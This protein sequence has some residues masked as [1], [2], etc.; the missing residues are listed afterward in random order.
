MPVLGVQVGSILIR[1]L[2]L[3]KY[4]R[5]FE[6]VVTDPGEPVIVRCEYYPDISRDILEMK[7]FVFTE[8]NDA[9]SVWR[10]P[11]LD[12]HRGW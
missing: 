2:G 4:T 8:R 3:P 7:E 5:S 1:A 11:Y 6:L 9:W 10:S 12:T